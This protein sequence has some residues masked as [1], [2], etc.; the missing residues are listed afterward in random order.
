MEILVYGFQIEE[1]N[2]W[3]YTDNPSVAEEIRQ[4][5]GIYRDGYAEYYY[6]LY[7]G[8]IE[9]TNYDNNII[10]TEFKGKLINKFI[11]YPDLCY[12]EDENKEFAPFYI[13]HVSDLSLPKSINAH[14]AV[15]ITTVIPKLD[16][17]GLGQ[18]ACLYAI[19]YSNPVIFV[20]HIMR[21]T[22]LSRERALDMAN[23]I[24]NKYFSSMD[25]CIIAE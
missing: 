12:I 11:P 19:Y 13:R 24:K 16:N 20:N 15:E 7:N 17:S 9:K 4:Y 18:T 23:Y 6:H 2:R 14:I 5:Y 10:G 3:L 1:E 8:R 21:I 25:N 22:G